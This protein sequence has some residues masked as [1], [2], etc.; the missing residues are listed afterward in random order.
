MLSQILTGLAGI[1]KENSIS[2]LGKFSADSSWISV[3]YSASD[4]VF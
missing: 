1:P 2:Q 4:T 3:I